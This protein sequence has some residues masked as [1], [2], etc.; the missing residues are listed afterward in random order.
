M[1]H[2]NAFYNTYWWILTL[3]EE[4]QPALQKQWGKAG[5]DKLNSTINIFRMEAGDLKYYI[6]FLKI[7]SAAPKS[8]LNQTSTRNALWERS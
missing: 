7:Y 2:S 8:I 4:I 1:G 6:F 5:S 3:K